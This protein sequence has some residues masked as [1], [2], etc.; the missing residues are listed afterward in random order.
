MI[1]SNESILFDSNI[2]IF[3]H[4]ID[5]L[6]Y[7][8]ANKLQEEVNNGVL[9]GVLTVQNLLEFYSVITNP[10]IIKHPL[11]PEHT[12]R[13]IRKFTASPF[14]I[15]FPRG[16]ELNIVD[17]LIKDNNL[18]GRKIFDVYLVATMLSNGVKIIYTQNEKDFKIFK[19]I[20]V[21]NPFKA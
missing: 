14:E 9:K 21:I 17:L 8:R 20:K 13:E 1:G 12:I 4:N 2:L 11:S 15:I 18:I 19:E 5:S 16:N 7:R 3:A 10:N 6:F